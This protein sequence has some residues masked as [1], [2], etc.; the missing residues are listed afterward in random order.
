ML[1]LPVGSRPKLQR[2]ELLRPRRMLGVPMI[3]GNPVE[4]GAKVAFGVGQ[5][6]ARESLHV[7]KWGRIIRRENEPEMMPVALASLSE[8]LMIAIVA[9]GTEHPGLFAVLGHAV[10]AE[11]GK[12]RGKRGAL[13]PMT[14]HA[15]FNHSA[16]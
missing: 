7:G 10:A 6:V 11:I 9:L 12:M 15:G 4:A 2:Q 3:D 16:A 13:R 14:N 5:E 1:N 8:G